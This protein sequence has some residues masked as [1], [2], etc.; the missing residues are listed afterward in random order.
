LK[1]SAW[2]V[3][4]IAYA[5]GFKDVTHFNNFFKKQVQQSP[6]RFRSV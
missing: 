4:D 5:L 6:F 3:S 1:H 2:K